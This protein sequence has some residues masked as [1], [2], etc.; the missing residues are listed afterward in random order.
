MKPNINLYASML[1]VLLLFG[2]CDKGPELT[3]AT[4]DGKNTFSCKVNGKV[5]IPKGS[6]SLGGTI[7]PIYGGFLWN[8]V[9]DSVD[10]SIGAYLTNSYDDQLDLYLKSFKLGVHRLNQKT[11]SEGATLNP[12]N[13]G[14]FRAANGRSYITSE[15]NTGW[16]NL[17]KADT[18][19]GII[20]GT[21]E[22]TAASGS[23]EIVKIT[24][25][26]FDIKSPQ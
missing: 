11:L 13:Y 8:V 6:S 15:I 26:R 25:G 17:T 9:T 22:F 20:A 12:K 4:Q 10:I 23:G 18:I 5:W 21:F 7:K 24:E 1:T 16:I 3:P 14:L 19:S 2:A